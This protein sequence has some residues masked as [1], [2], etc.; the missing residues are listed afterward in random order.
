MGRS[1]RHEWH[2]RSSSLRRPERAWR[3]PSGNASD[4]KRVMA[5]PLHRPHRRPEI[6]AP[7]FQALPRDAAPSRQWASLKIPRGIGSRSARA[8]SVSAEASYQSVSP[9]SGIMM[10]CGRVL[11]GHRRYEGDVQVGVEGEES[12]GNR[13]F[14]RCVLPLHCPHKAIPGGRADRLGHKGRVTGKT[15]M[16]L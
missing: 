14:R 1:Q 10:N 12:A 11:A 9:M 4:T 15:E 2:R 7:L 3:R 5:P 13:Q 16:P 8:S 6:R